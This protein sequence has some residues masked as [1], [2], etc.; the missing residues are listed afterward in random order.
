MLRSLR[1]GHV[2]GARSDD[3]ASAVRHAYAGADAA[4]ARIGCVSRSVPDRIC[5]ADVER[6]ALDGVADLRGIVWPEQQAAACLRQLAEALRV[7]VWFHRIHEPDGVNH[8]VRSAYLAEE[9]VVCR[10][11]R[12]VAAVADHDEDLALVFPGAQ[13]LDAVGNRIVQG[14]T[15]SGGDRLRER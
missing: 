15:A 13:V 3:D 2:T 11:A 6:H 8:D 10:F 7:R 5:T 9:L 12:V 14:R 4:K 1:A